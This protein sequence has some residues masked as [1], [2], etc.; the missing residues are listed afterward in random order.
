MC[1]IKLSVNG[2]GKNLYMKNEIHD[3]LG[4]SDSKLLES[5]TVQKITKKVKK[6]KKS[7]TKTNNV[8][9]VNSTS[10]NG[11][12]SVFG[13]VDNKILGTA[14]EY[15]NKHNI[16]VAGNVIE[17]NKDHLDSYWIMN[18]HNCKQTINIDRIRLVKGSEMVTSTILD[19]NRCRI[20]SI[21]VNSTR[22]DDLQEYS[23]TRDI[24]YKM[25]NV[26]NHGDRHDLHYVEISLK[27][28][29]FI[30]A[31]ELSAPGRYVCFNGGIVSQHKVCSMDI[32]KQFLIHTLARFPVEFRNGITYDSRL[33]AY[34]RYYNQKM[35]ANLIDQFGCFDE[36]EV[37]MTLRKL[38]LV[39]H[40]I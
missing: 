17:Q 6:S 5:E 30:T 18:R 38:G 23:N 14:V 10:E 2:L 19:V 32:R 28:M 34:A 12:V 37:V 29:C 36:T 22:L 25:K 9:S 39:E 15:L 11:L 16:W 26:E 1:K 24:C 21:M 4:K 31:C 3:M 7:K 35:S 13:N 8:N 40:V 33:Q 20:V 27:N